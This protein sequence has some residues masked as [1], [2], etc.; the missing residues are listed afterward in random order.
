MRDA[1]NDADSEYALAEHVRAERVRFVFI[2][3]ALPIV[4][5]PIAAVV[6][7]LTLWSA[8]DHRR[9]VWF[10]VGAATIAALRIA[11]TIR[12]RHADADEHDI[13]RWETFFVVSIMAVDLWWG[14]G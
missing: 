5:S 12:F 14:A 7:A 3:S 8:I 9:L 11:T 10:A 13:R 4:F 1:P 2:Q 6:L